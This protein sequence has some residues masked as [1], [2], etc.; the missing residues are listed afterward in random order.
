MVSEAEKKRREF[1]PRER[2]LA[3]E[4][5]HLMEGERGDEQR[6]GELNVMG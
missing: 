5:F 2:K 1:R 6:K 3:R 4:R